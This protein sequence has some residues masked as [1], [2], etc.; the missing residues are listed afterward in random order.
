MKTIK[1]VKTYTESQV[2]VFD[3]YVLGNFEF[4]KRF[5]TPNQKDLG[6][7]DKLF[8][9]ELDLTKFGSTEEFEEEQKGDSYLA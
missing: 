7:G 8:F 3:F 1:T 4:L 6:Q 9:T 5:S 2:A